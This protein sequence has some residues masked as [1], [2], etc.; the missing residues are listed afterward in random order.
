[1]AVWCQPP[2]VYG[3]GAQAVHVWRVQLD[4][5]LFVAP[6]LSLLSSDELSKM[7]GYR[8]ERDRN[9]FV[10]ARGVLRVLLA[11]YL[12]VAASNIKMAYGPNGKP[13]LANGVADMPL[14]FN[15]SHSGNLALMA[16]TAEGEMGVDLEQVKPGVDIDGAASLFLAKEEM[17]ELQQKPLADRPECFYRYW[18]CK[19]AYL[20]ARGTG[21][22]I[23]PRGFAMSI[24]GAQPMLLKAS[25]CDSYPERWSFSWINV[26]PDVLAAIACADF[27]GP[28]PQY[29]Y[30]DFLALD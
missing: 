26:A 21:I 16:F 28:S 3:L 8:H 6:L 18:V 7:Q 24:S 30:Y 11:R 19:E 17:A 10:L 29:K 25:S 4:N 12:G 9:R 5:E 23:P 14:S 1:M 22:T 13:R 27:A 20:K 15:V 2:G